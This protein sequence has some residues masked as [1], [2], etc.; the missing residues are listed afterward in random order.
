MNRNDTVDVAD[1]TRMPADVDAPDKVAYGLTWRQLAILAVA[2]M[3]FYGTWNALRT[4]VPPQVIVVVGAVLG[5]ALFG[6]IV[7]RRDGLP[8]DVWL[9]HAIRHLRSPK[10]LSP[11]GEPTAGVP[12]WVQPQKGRTPWPAPLRLPADAIDADGEIT[13]GGDRAAIVAATNINLTLRTGSEQAALIEGFGRWLNSLSTPTQVLVSAQPVD[14]ASH[15][16]TVADAAPNQPHPALQAAC[17]DHAAFLADLAARRDPLRRQVLVVTRTASG[18]QGSP[19]ARRRADD[20]VRALSGLGV[21]ARTLKRPAATAALVAAADPYRPP[22]PGG[23]AAPDAVI[24]MTAT[25]AGPERRT[26]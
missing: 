13:I 2:G 15:A 20:A 10:G 23:L 16:R 4:V 25:P 1:R 14:L 9:V 24:T 18:E 11:A 6:L 21:T 22:R 8:L 19:G 3:L 7:G 26:L 17:A 12:D 5:A